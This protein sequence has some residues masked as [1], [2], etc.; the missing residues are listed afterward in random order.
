MRMKLSRSA[1]SQRTKKAWITRKRNSPGIHRKLFYH[2]WQ[3]PNAES[4]RLKGFHREDIKRIEP[5]LAGTDN[6]LRPGVQLRIKSIEK[7]NPYFR[8]KAKGVAATTKT[9]PPFRSKIRISPESFQKKSKW[10]PAGLIAH[11]IGHAM[12]PEKRATRNQ[13]KHFEQSFGW[14]PKSQHDLYRTE[15]WKMKRDNTLHRTLG[16]KH[17]RQA[18]NADEDFAETYRS[19]L[20]LN[21]SK[22]RRGKEKR[23][24]HTTVDNARMEHMYK[25]YMR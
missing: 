21:M 24:F 4:V 10:E 14:K 18:L 22:T 17:T 8:A 25:Y 5:A 9:R 1:A 16:K 6:T 12:G 3:R 20:G 15:N 23:Y 13:L 7:K 19:T 2:Q 11:E